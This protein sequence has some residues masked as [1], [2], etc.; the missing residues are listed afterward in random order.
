M[1]ER[2]IFLS[3][4]C[5][6]IL[7]MVAATHMQLIGPYFCGNAT[8]STRNI[9]TGS[10]FLTLKFTLPIILEQ[11]TQCTG[12]RIIEMSPLLNHMQTPGC[13]ETTTQHKGA[14]GVAQTVCA[15]KPATLR[16][17]LRLHKLEKGP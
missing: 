17:L 16:W 11:S 9:L 12:G 7:V 2:N 6:I 5:F 10:I 8:T 4:F 13:C 14:L 15:P 1:R 3:S